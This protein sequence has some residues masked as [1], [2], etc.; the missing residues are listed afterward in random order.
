MKKDDSTVSEKQGQLTGSEQKPV[1]L[2]AIRLIRHEEQNQIALG[3]EARSGKQERRRAHEGKSMEN[4]MDQLIRTDSAYDPNAIENTWE[5][6]QQS[7]PIGWLAAFCILLLAI[8][9]G[10][11]R[12]IES[13]RQIEH[14]ALV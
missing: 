10:A 8:G 11:Y 13:N 3:A 5:K 9:F 4:T 14:N 6:D 12:W 1:R 7:I 2:E